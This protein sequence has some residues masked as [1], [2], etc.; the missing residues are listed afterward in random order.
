VVYEP[1]SGNTHVVN[2][3]SHALLEL[4]DQHGECTLDELV[5][6]LRYD[7]PDPPNFEIAAQQVELS[8]EEL[9]G[10]GLVTSHPR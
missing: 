3:L 5:E 6:A 7:G 10:V 4:L 1:G 2:T 8:L 9:Q